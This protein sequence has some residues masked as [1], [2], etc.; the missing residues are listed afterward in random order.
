MGSEEK[1][2]GS[3]GTTVY[4]EQSFG[5]TVKSKLKLEANFAEIEL[6]ALITDDTSFLKVSAATTKTQRKH[7]L[8]LESN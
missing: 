5:F 8:H 2:D 6:V 7:N 3:T 4:S 1:E